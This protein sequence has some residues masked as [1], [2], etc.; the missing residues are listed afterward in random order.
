MAHGCFLSI[1][2]NSEVY[3]IIQD[4]STDGII[5]ARMILK[6]DTLQKWIDYLF[7]R[8]RT[9]ITTEKFAD[10]KEKIEKVAS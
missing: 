5:S 8:E 7:Q 1:E 2:R 6:Q 10:N 4:E 3:Y 9:I